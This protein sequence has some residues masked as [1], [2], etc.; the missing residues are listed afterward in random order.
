MNHYLINTPAIPTR[1]PRCRAWVLTAHTSGCL[2]NVDPIPLD[3][4]EELVALLDDR[5]TFDTHT[6]KYM[7]SIYLEYR[8]AMRIQASRNH[9]VVTT[10]KCGHAIGTP[11]P[12]P[13]RSQPKRRHSDEPPF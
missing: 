8:T 5:P 12:A 11:P 13:P 1:C 6:E 2:V 4:N 10:H 7:Y 3:E 9:P